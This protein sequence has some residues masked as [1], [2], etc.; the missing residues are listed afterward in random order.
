MLQDSIFVCWNRMKL[1][2]G[3]SR[4]TV[5]KGLVPRKHD[6]LCCMGEFVLYCNFIFIGGFRWI[7]DRSLSADPSGP[8]ALQVEEYRTIDHAL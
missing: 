8:N 1:F 2:R 3:M 5:L 4:A 6:S 7:F